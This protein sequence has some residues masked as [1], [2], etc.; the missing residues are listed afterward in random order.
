MKIVHW[1]RLRQGVQALS[2]LLSLVLVVYTLRDVGGA[3]A[4]DDL[5]SLDPL[6]G[7]AAMLSTR[8]WLARFVPALVLLGATLAL[9]RF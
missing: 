1:R 2:L 7:A 9:G 4:A 6:V 3:L 5:L 8:H